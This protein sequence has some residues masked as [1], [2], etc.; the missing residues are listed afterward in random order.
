MKV[1]R[2][3]ATTLS[4]GANHPRTTVQSRALTPLC[5][6]SP[7]PRCGPNLNPG[8]IWGF[9]AK[10]ARDVSTARVQAVSPVTEVKSSARRSA[11]PCT[12]ADRLL[13]PHPHPGLPMAPARA[14]L[15][16]DDPSRSPRPAV[17]RALLAAAPRRPAL[18]APCHAGRNRSVRLSARVD[19]QAGEHDAMERGICLTAATTVE[20]TVLPAARGT[21]NG[22]DP[23]QSCKRRL[24]AQP[25]RFVPRRDQQ[26]DGRVRT[27]PHHLK[28]LRGM[29]FHEPGQTILH[30]PDLLGQPADP[31]SQQTQRDPSGLQHRFLTVLLAT[32]HVSEPRTGTEEFG[33]AQSG[34]FFP[35]GWIGRP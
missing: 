14:D 20:A 9:S 7:R 13:P 15:R 30:I 31:V 2:S 24:T 21:L 32:A 3:S 6:Q 23:A 27:D 5:T 4:R 16:A 8:R 35:Q 29:T 26:S 33:I 11:P 19:P 18:A 34:Q 28:Q 22:T 25:F 10:A 12:W 17:E 1:P